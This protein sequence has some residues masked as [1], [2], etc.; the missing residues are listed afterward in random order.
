M[1]PCSA[2]SRRGLAAVGLWDDAERRPSLTASARDV[3]A[4]AGRDEETVV[5]SNKETEGQPGRRAAVIAAL[6]DGWFCHGVPR[7][8]TV[9]TKMS[10]FLAQAMSARLCPFPAAISRR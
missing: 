4:M 7:A 9:L 3:V 6:G 1:T 8:T 5:A 2:P 10:S